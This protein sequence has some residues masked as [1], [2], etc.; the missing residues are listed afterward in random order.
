MKRAK[1]LQPLSRQHHLGLHVA[2]HARDCLDDSQQISEH[3]QALS[4]YVTA[5]GEHFDSEYSLMVKGLLSH[6]QSHP[7]A[8]SVV[9]KLQNQQRILHQ[10]LADIETNKDKNTGNPSMVE[11]RS[12]AT[13]LYEHIRFEERELL[14]AVAQ[15]LTDAELNAIYQASPDY[16]KNLDQQ[17]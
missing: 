10:Q 3:W 12:F 13:S 7:E 15:Y 14:P 17:R 9:K 11:V 4:S 8:A 2:H 5:M 6:S 16:V 1:Q